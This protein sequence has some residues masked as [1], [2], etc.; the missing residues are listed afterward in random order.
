MRVVRIANGAGF[1]GD[2]ITAPR[3]LVE[4]AT[5]DYLTIEHLA[6][7]T[8]SILARQREKD[9]KAGYAEDFVEIIR[10]LC[11]PLKKQP[12]L[13]IIANSGGMNPLACAAAVSKVLKDA[14]L[15][16]TVI[17]VVTGD[18]LMQ[19]LAAAEFRNL[20]TDE[21]LSVLPREKIV[22][23]NAYLGARP[24]VA[25]LVAGARIVITG[26]VADASLTV[27]PLV[28]EFGW[29]WDDLPKIAAAT[30]AGHL[31]E[32]GAQVTGG[33]ATDWEHS[34]LVNVGYPIAEVNEAGETIIT[35]P[36]NTGGCVNFRTVAE[37]LV[38]EIGDP[39]RYYTPDIVCDF[40]TVEL[41][42]LGNDRVLVTG[43]S[44]S[45][46]TS[47]YKV[48]LA[49]RDGFMASGQLLVYGLDCPAKAQAC[50]EMILQRTA[51]AGFPLARTNIELL[52]QGAGVPGSWFWRKYQPPGEVMLRV[53]VHDP[54]RA[55]VEHFTREIAPL[56]TSGPAGLA[57]YAAGRPSVR[58]VFAYWPTLIPK[59]LVIAKVQVQTAEKF[60]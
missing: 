47:T 51:A 14:G 59:S 29:S 42:D 57:G 8:M 52:G 13:K 17:G 33:Y 22:S 35:K 15:G 56:I 25:A 10:S 55:A 46:A 34:H 23:A 18:D 40:T 50:G 3:E 7:L 5:V 24:I 20:D 36:A 12:Q 43:A 27:A 58:P 39:H 60:A 1:L 26:R 16:D 44:G 37:Q 21:P 4:A 53:T 6:E 45:D 31:I 48:S 19:D 38:Y 30:V 49:Y 11:E 32:C 2:R 9:P 54:N 41:K 28:H